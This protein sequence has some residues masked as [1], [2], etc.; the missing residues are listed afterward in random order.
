MKEEILENGEL[1][2][3]EKK[4]KGKKKKEASKVFFF[5]NMFCELLPRQLP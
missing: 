3:R 1:A 5:C 2:T 4:K